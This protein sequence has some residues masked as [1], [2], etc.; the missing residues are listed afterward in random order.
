MRI[1]RGAGGKIIYEHGYG[2]ANLDYSIPITPESNFY[3]AST[4]KQFTRLCRRPLGATGKTLA[5]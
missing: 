1:G 3:I 4:S 5:Q 2:M